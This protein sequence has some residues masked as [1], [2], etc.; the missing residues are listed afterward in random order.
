VIVVADA[1]PL[2]Y[3]VLIAAV[4]VLHP[5]YDHVVVPETVAEE[6]LLDFEAALARLGQTNF[7]ISVELVNHMRRRLRG[8]KES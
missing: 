5:L 2:H 4:D 7:Y 1:S 8:E 3:L 6:Y